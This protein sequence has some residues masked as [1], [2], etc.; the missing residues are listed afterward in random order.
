MIVA[1]IV[2]LTGGAALSGQHAAHHRLAV[3]YGVAMG[4]FIAAY[5]VW[6]RR[7]VA[8]LLIAPLL[9]D[10]GTTVTGVVLLAPLAARRWPEV[11]R[12][13]RER[14][15]DA[16]AVAGLSSIS[17]ILVLTALA[18]TP[19]SYIA[20]VREVSIVFGAFIG[21]HRLKE[22]EGWR[23]IFAAAAIAVGI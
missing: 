7:G 2:L 8:S 21:A 16:T 15:L 19:V 23:R 20:S 9:H 3:A 10:A 17:C 5:T 12:E 22:A 4:I 18:V 13:L 6:D 1:S 14:R 11:M